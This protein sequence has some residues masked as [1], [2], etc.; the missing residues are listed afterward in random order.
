[1][2]NAKSSKEAKKKATPG[3]QFKITLSQSEPPIW[4]RILVANGTLDDLHEYIQAAMGW[5]DSHLHQ[6]KIRGQRYG[7]PEMLNDGFGEAEIIDTLGVELKRLFGIGRP[8]RSFIYEYDFGDGWLHEV[9][10]EG[11]REVP[12]NK[13]CPCCLGGE[14]ACPPEDVGGM[15]GY[16]DFLMAIRDPEHEEHH[17][18][19]EWVGEEFDS[20]TFNIAKATRAMRR[21][22]PTWRDG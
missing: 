9:E 13:S 16:I 20:E 10:F 2:P 11:L 21:G 5:T 4:R 17:A 1:M 19:V 7:N 22:L 3:F 8:P 15:F 18:Y 6:F 14:R 12:K